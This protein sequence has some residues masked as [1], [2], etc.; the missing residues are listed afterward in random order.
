[1]QTYQSSQLDALGDPTRRA[2]VERLLGGPLPV[3]RLAHGLSVSRPA[4]SQHLRVLED[5]RLVTFHAAGTRRIYAL[6]S[7]GFA[8]LREYLDRFWDGALAAFKAEVESSHPPET[9]HE[10]LSSRGRR[11]TSRRKRRTRP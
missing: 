6:D 8:A 5:A 4:V 7:T 2:I 9:E 1:M 10:H 3:G 11:S